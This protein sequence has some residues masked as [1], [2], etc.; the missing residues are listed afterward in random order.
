MTQPYLGE[1]RMFGGNFAPR[2]WM[3]CQGQLLSISQYS[4]LFSLIGTTYGGDGTSTF[5]LPNLQS[6]VAMGQGNGAGLTSRV[7]G[8]TGGQET[9]TLTVNQIPGHM[10]ALSGTTT[11]AAAGGQTPGSGVTLGTPSASGGNLYVVDDGSTPPPT[12]ESLPPA[13][14]SQAGNSMPHDNIMPVLCVNYI[15]AMNGI[16][17]SRN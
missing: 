13:S 12:A 16:F 6:R 17:P 9:V 11:V 2:Q 7:I 15:I 14:C 3:L 10:H 4:A 8:Q 5:A 1:I